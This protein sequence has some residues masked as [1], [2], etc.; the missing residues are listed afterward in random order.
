MSGA[1]I[2]PCGLTVRSLIE[3]A[4]ISNTDVKGLPAPP[5]PKSTIPTKD[6]YEQYIPDLFRLPIMDIKPGDQVSELRT[7]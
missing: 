2:A 6:P 3:T 4:V 1:E 5:K 7:R